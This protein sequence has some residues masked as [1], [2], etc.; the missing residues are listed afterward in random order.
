MIHHGRFY[1]AAALGLALW[2]GLHGQV[3]EPLRLVIAGDGFFVTYLTITAFFLTRLTPARMRVR[4]Q[5]EDEGILIIAL[6]TLAAVSLSLH[7]IFEILNSKGEASPILIAFALLGVPLG[8]FTFH[9]VMAFHYAHLYYLPDK[10]H[11]DVGGLDFPGTKEPSSWDFLYYSFVVGMTAQV[12]DVDV[13]SANMRKVTLIQSVIAFFYNTILLALA[14]NV[15]VN[16][17]N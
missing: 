1:S 9:T 12:S 3:D 11:A 14:V 10:K 15:A 17:A 6:I 4:S 13:T 5:I 7:A 2:F 16:S 8:W